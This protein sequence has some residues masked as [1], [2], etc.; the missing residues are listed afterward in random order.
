MTI[1]RLSARAL[2]K[3]WFCKIHV[4]YEM[5]TNKKYSQKIKDLLSY[6]LLGFIYQKKS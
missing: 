2:I 3:Q 5:N 4:F 6:Y 1:N